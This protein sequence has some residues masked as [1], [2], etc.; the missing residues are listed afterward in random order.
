MKKNIFN[1]TELETVVTKVLALAK[2]NGA[3][4]AETEIGVGTGFSVT[5]RMGEVE[6]LEHNQDKSI[7]VTVYFG[8]KSGSASTSD[9]NDAAL[10]LTVAKA[11]NIAKFTG[12]DPCSGLAEKELLAFNYPDLNLYHSWNIT[13]ERAIELASEC[14]NIARDQDKRITNSEGA[15]ISTHD[16]FHGYGNSHDFMGSYMSSHHSLSCILIANDGHEMQRDHD[17]ATAT[18]PQQLQD[19][20]KIAI[21]AAQRTVRRLGARRLSTRRCPIIFAPEVAR[22]LMGNLISAISGGNLY[23]NASFLL[24]QLDQK[25]FPD[26]VHIEECPHLLA[27]EGS[28]PFDDEGVLTYSKNIIQTGTLK[29]YILSSYSARK[30][31]MKTTANAGGVHNLI[32]HSTTGGLNEL[33]SQM[34]TGLLVT[35][36]IGVGVNI[37]TGD[38]SRGAF[39]YWVED[40][41]IQY[42]VQE[43]TIAGNLKDMF[44]HVIA[45]GDDVDYRGNVKT[46]SVLIEEMTVAGQ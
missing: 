35:E 4:A 31:G 37:V 14:E 10:Q 33:L 30:L 12:E 15:S 16:Y 46:G 20:K 24:N 5:V 2:Q 25:V 39:G 23:R 40:G 3:T 26:F 22:S 8:K 36:L 19:I 42:P 21:S 38:Y 27:A 9:F 45:I 41:V 6:M 7:D 17:Y 43:I 11:C 32:V 29:T 18:E 13:P 34:G 28:A 44:A 1:K